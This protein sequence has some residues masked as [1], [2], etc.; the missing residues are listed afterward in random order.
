MND[1]P[2]DFQFL[3]NLSTSSAKEVPK[4]DIGVPL[5]HLPRAFDS[6]SFFFSFLIPRLI[7][8]SRSG[9]TRRCVETGPHRGCSF[10]YAGQVAF[11]NVQSEPRWGDMC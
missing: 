1:I 7:E 8:V 10:F 4:Q 5:F 3:F 9:G 11:V 6:F 2:S